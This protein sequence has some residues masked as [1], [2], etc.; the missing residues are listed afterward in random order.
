[1]TE[2]PFN[3]LK[4]IELK[5]ILD[6]EIA[7]VVIKAFVHVYYYIQAEPTDGDEQYPS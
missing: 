4:K 6:V 3:L 7:I 2:R 5:E 1:M